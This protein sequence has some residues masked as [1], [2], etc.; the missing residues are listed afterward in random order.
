M[1]KTFFPAGTVCVYSSFGTLVRM[2]EHLLYLEEKAK[3]HARCV[4]NAFLKEKQGI[5]S[6]WRQQATNINVEKRVTPMSTT[7]K[8][9]CM[10]YYISD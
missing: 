5:V 9:H 4:R 7:P 8:A 10:R 2:K 3:R 1:A 6:V